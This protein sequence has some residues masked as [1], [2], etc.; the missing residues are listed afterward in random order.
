ME[1]IYCARNSRLCGRSAD[2]DD[3]EV[4]AEE[5]QLVNRAATCFDILYG[6]SSGGMDDW[7]NI[8]SARQPSN[9]RCPAPFFIFSSPRARC[10][11]RASHAH[12]DRCV[13]FQTRR[14]AAAMLV[15]AKSLQLQLQPRVLEKARRSPGR[16]R[17]RTAPTSPSSRRSSAGQLTQ[18]AVMSAAEK[19]KAKFHHTSTRKNVLLRFKT[20]PG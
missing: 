19:A 16:R 12:A 6:F 15:A 9:P 2:R 11:P 10:R 17:V 8:F 20:E 18:T 14:I 1:K 4:G 5:H 7:N 3:F 13:H